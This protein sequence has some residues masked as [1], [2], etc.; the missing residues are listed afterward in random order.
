MRAGRLAV[1]A[2]LLSAC[3]GAPKPAPHAA[4][5]TAP[6]GVLVQPYVLVVT[7]PTACSKDQGDIHAVVGA[8]ARYAAVRLEHPV[9]SKAAPR[10][11]PTGTILENP[12]STELQAV[13]LDLA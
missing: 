4:L 9:S 5:T 6:P 1:V 10:V 2:A 11:E 3:G 13:M 12:T 7:G 8:D